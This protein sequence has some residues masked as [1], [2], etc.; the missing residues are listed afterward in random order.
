LLFLKLLHQHRLFFDQLEEDLFVLVLAVLEL[1]VPEDFEDPVEQDFELVVAVLEHMLVVGDKA[2]EDKDKV[3][4][5][6][7]VEDMA[8]E[9]MVGEDMAA[10]DMDMVVEDMDMVVGDMDKVADRMVV[11]DKDLVVVRLV[12]T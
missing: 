8:V 12:E 4:G 7:V 5:D 1:V 6:M 3:V 10:V 2:V 11:E 9:G